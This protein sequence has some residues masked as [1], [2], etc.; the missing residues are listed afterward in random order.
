MLFSTVTIASHVEEFPF[1]SVTVSV[2]VL[3]PTLE[4]L[5]DN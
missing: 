1:T 3:S 2:T 5:K 4:Q